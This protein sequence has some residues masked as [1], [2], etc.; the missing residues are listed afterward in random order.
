MSSEV[1]ELYEISDSVPRRTCKARTSIVNRPVS[2]YKFG[3]LGFVERSV[4]WL[5]GGSNHSEE[6]RNLTVA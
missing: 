3:L 5:V 6:L 4:S 2:A 1:T